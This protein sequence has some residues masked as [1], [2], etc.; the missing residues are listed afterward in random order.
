MKIKGKPPKRI[1][2]KNHGPYNVG[3]WVMVHTGKD[4]RVGEVIG[5][6]SMLICNVRFYTNKVWTEVESGLERVEFTSVEHL[7]PVTSIAFTLPEEVVKNLLLL[8]GVEL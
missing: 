4:P 2:T 8:Q 6:S 1:E 7:V 5:T 3:D